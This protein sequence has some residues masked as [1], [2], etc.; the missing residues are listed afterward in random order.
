MA[1][2]MKHADGHHD[3]LIFDEEP[4]RLNRHLSDVAGIDPK[5][6]G[7]TV[8]GAIRAV[9]DSLE[10][11]R[12]NPSTSEVMKV[13]RAMKQGL[14]ELKARHGNGDLFNHRIYE[15]LIALGAAAAANLSSN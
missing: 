7:G 8:R 9:L 6:H 2:A 10:N 1:C 15:E 13:Y 3:F 12:G 5:I 11:P 4:H 14:R